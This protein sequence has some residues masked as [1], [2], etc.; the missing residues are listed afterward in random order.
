MLGYII[1]ASY[2]PVHKPKLG[3]FVAILMSRLKLPQ[4]CRL[5]RVGIRPN[6]LLLKEIIVHGS[7]QLRGFWILD[8]G[9]LILAARKVFGSWIMAMN[10]EQAACPFTI[11]DSRL[12]LESPQVHHYSTHPYA[13]SICRLLP[14]TSQ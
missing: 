1:E 5:N 7:W 12:T 8:S 10:H 6:R 3:K 11:H 13:F 2:L 14:S 9:Y 4:T